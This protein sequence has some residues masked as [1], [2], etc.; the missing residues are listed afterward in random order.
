MEQITLQQETIQALQNFL[1]IWRQ[2]PA[3]QHVLEIYPNNHVMLWDITEPEKVIDISKEIEKPQKTIN[4][5]EFISS[6]F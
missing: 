3:S 5:D 1:T 6:I 4:I 2:D